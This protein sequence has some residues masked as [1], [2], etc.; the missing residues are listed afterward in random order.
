MTVGDHVFFN[1]AIFAGQVSFLFVEAGRNFEAQD[2]RFTNSE[3]HVSFKEMKVGEDALINRSI[4]QGSVDFRDV[5]INGN[6]DANETQFQSRKYPVLFNSIQAKFASFTGAIFSGPA[7]FSYSEIDFNLDMHKAY[8]K[9]PGVTTIFSEMTIGKS[10]FLAETVFDGAVNFE[11]I[12]IGNALDLSGCQFNN[13]EEQ[14]ASLSSMNVGG[15]IFLNNT[16]FN[17]P[18]N[19]SRTVTKGLVAADTNWPKE[20][21]G[22]NVSG[23]VFEE[24]DVHG[25]ENNKVDFISLLERSPFER[26]SY[27]RLED[28]YNRLGYPSFADYVFIKVNQRERREHLTWMHYRWWWNGFLDIFV[29]YGRD[30]LRAAGWCLLI[31]ILGYFVFRKKEKM[32]ML[33]E[34]EWPYRPFLYSLDLF[35]PL[36]DLGYARRW[37]PTPERR[38]ARVYAKI[39]QYLA[40]ILIPVALL[41]IAGVLD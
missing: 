31:V 34:T 15:F 9:D 12:D 4:F 23:L 19:L 41:A 21:N 10:F 36:V 6:L 33:V 2:A 5:R 13:V 28:Y 24:I 20:E 26:Q 35:L 39:H 32:K 22:T 30:P 37:E 3:Q 11:Y 40:W 18:V 17:G 7:D 8:F 16:V 27:Q 38:A 29:L 14:T 1:E 25:S